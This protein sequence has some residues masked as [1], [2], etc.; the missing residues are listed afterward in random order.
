VGD[1]EWHADA[2]CREHTGWWLASAPTPAQ[3]LKDNA[4]RRAICSTCPVLAEC[5]AHIDRNRHHIGMWAGETEKQRQRRWRTER[6]QA[7]DPR[8]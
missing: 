1:L 4:K 2:A 5:R 6:T 3:G 7:K 8:S